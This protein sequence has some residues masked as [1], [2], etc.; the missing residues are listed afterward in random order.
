MPK[1][2]AQPIPLNTF[3][4]DGAT[5]TE[6]P[7]ER[8]P[9]GPQATDGDSAEARK[10]WIAEWA[11]REEII[12]GDAL[13][14]TPG[15]SVTTL[16]EF[17]AALD[18][19]LREFLL[20][21]DFLEAARC[22][23]EL[24]APQF[25][26]H[27][28]KRAVVLAMDKGGREREMIAVLL[29]SLHVRRV[30]SSQHVADGFAL[31]LE[32][33]ED[34][35]LDIPDAAGLVSHFLA[36]SHLDGLLPLT[37]LEALDT[38]A[39]A[40]TAA[41]GVLAQARA[42]LKGRVPLTGSQIDSRAVRAELRN[43]VNEYLASRDVT[44]VGRRTAEL[45]VP[46]DL[47]FELVRAAIELGMERGN[48]ERELVSQLLSDLHEEWLPLSDVS[49]GFEALL[50]RVDD[51]ALDNPRAVDQLAA[52]MTRAVADEILPPAFVTTPLP[53]KL[54]TPAQLAALTQARAP[55]LASHFGERRRH[56]WGAAADGSLAELKKEVAELWQECA[57]SGEVG[58]AVRCVRELEAPN[59]HHEVVKRAVGASIVDGG[60]REF[61]LCL[62][63]TTALSAADVLTGEQ[64]ALGC[65][66]LV[67][68]AEDLQLDYPKAP[69]L[70][71]Q[72]LERCC[73]LKLLAPAEE[74]SATAA[75]LRG[76][77]KPNGTKPSGP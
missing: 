37:M 34:L 36:D 23:V 13:G 57:I 61:E 74:W 59:Y 64:L 20:G 9:E 31:L 52:F 24:G 3:L 26:P 67:E 28:V 45:G 8:L 50:T 70:L 63:L 6:A 77:I 25:H 35:L 60:P 72:Y 76:G 18:L 21:G 38:S 29:S 54:A 4:A 65:T 12:D 66:R 10:V 58:E 56:V 1:N 69:E 30:L 43:V 55:L 53:E 51:L 32:S 49:R 33:I 44:E 11:G 75:T 62:Q 2:K 40:D 48:S 68:S 27:V 42:R 73:A 16:D 14:V 19:N 46:Y 39:P 5:P 22:I 15:T 47:Q 71:A 41:A 7:G 17:K